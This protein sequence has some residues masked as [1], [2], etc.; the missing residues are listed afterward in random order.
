VSGISYRATRQA[1]RKR[2]AILA[3]GVFSLL[4]ISFLLGRLT[5]PSDYIPVEGA[6]PTP[7]ITLAIFPKDFLPKVKD[8]T[9]NVLNGSRRVGLATITAEVLGNRG[10]QIGEI[11]NFD[12]YPV[13]NVAEIHHGAKGKDAA[14]LA[15][16]YI[17]GSLLV[18]DERTDGSVDVI[19]G[20]AFE[21]LRT[22]EQVKTEMQKPVPS[23]SGPG[24]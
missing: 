23:P 16:L 1:R 15:S 2:L 6:E 22:E 24:C 7:C 11:S 18:E 13:K 5:K 4:L 3:A 14:Y 9:I 20:Q 10:F 8:T 12:E 21:D 17:D 19:I